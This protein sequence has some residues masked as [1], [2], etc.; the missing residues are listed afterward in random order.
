LDD[1][2]I[3][4]VVTGSSWQKLYALVDKLFAR[5]LIQSAEFVPAPAS[6]LVRA[7]YHDSQA[8]NAL[9]QAKA[10]NVGLIRSLVS[11]TQLE[12]A[13]TQETPAV[14]ADACGIS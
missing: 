9:I 14:M 11:K 10:T 6:S 8:A 3:E 2:L 1:D 5:Q 7:I 13:I 12:V 4:L